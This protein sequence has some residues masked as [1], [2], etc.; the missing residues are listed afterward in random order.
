MMAWAFA[1]LGS[2]DAPLLYAISSASR[3]SVNA[4]GPQE[5]SNLSWSCAPIAFRDDPLLE[6][7]ASAAVARIS[8]FHP[9]DLGNTAW[10]LATLG[11]SD[12]PLMDAIAEAARTRIYDDPTT[13]PQNLTNIAWAFATLM[14]KN[15]ELFEAIA[16]HAIKTLDNFNLQNMSNTAWAFAKLGELHEELF[17]AI[18]EAALRRRSEWSTQ[19]C[20]NFA[21][22]FA[23]IGLRD[24]ELMQAISA[25]AIANINEFSTQ[26]LA[27]LAWAFAMLDIWDRPLMAAIAAAAL[28][29]L[30]E[31]A[32][33]DLAY[34]AWSFAQLGLHNDPLLDALSSEVLRRINEFALED[35]AKTAWS[36]ATFSRDAFIPVV[37]AACELAIRRPPVSTW[38]S[39][40]ML[41]TA[42][43]FVWSAWIT[44]RPDLAWQL[45]DAWASKGMVFDAASFGMLLM[46]SAYSKKEGNESAILTMIQRC[47]VFDDLKDVFSWCTGHSLD[48]SVPDYAM[49]FDVR[50]CP[51]SGH[52]R[53]T[54]AKLALLVADMLNSGA[55]DA[56]SALE[57]VR[58]HSYGVG[59]WL[60]VAGGAKANLI[61]ENIRSRPAKR[62][63]EVA[64]EFGVF[65][66]YTTM[67]LG[68]RAME[69]NRGKEVVPL[70]V[71]LEVE[72]VHVC[73]ARWMV[74]LAGLSRCVEVWA[75]MAHDLLLRV[76]DEFGQRSAR[77]CFMD[78]RGTKFHE[79][80][81]RLELCR[82][83][84]LEATIIA[85]NVLKPSAPAFLWVTNKSQSYETVNYAL[86]EFV[87]YYVE[88]WMVVAHYLG[89]SADKGG[90]IAW[91]PATLRR[92]AW[93]SD[94]WRR[95]SEEDSVRTDEW[96]SFSQHARKIFM[97]CGIEARP[98]LN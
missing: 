40:E 49:R 15:S 63:G 20:A 61:E 72:P 52:M 91:P 87:Q 76:G 89:P 60:K 31:F 98:W 56:P 27:N 17:A 9:Q 65:V 25:A 12:M 57:A 26:S 85:D 10:A 30:K 43:A 3:A 1:T 80:L 86:G 46:D 73:V 68:H 93:D 14:V 97:D 82:L 83:L 67:R 88:D 53:G 38:N 66:G 42:H 16:E 11:I 37:H 51:G 54:H 64:L 96:A 7:L 29:S 84:A 92:L 75:G 77:L 78:H 62:H 48:S 47:S 22:S 18:A 19:D 58:Q 70:V 21:W 55:D 94:K 59:Q 23:K 81:E 45:L 36:W 69:N 6:A 35:L 13:S 50:T 2:W 24:E 79:D 95:K 5:I 90:S 28:P 34:L 32:A 4:F 44:A 33:H 8:D 41:D 71:G 39:A 74:D